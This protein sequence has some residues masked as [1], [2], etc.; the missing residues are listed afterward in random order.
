MSIDIGQRAGKRAYALRTPTEVR[1]AL[2][3]VLQNHAHHGGRPGI[4]P[5]SS[6]P[7]FPHWLGHSSATVN[8]P[9][10]MP[11]TWSLRLGFLEKGGGPIGVHEL[12]S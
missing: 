2:V 7:W 8:S 5:W 11:R 6:A 10:A 4:D 9:V 3:Y 12:P 1:R